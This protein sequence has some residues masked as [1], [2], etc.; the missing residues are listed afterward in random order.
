MTLNERELKLVALTKRL[1]MMKVEKLPPFALGHGYLWGNITFRRRLKNGNLKT[2]T[3]KTC[4][5]GICVN[6]FTEAERLARTVDGVDCVF[7]NID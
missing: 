7:I 2:I 1:V 5:G 6:S 3:V 4:F